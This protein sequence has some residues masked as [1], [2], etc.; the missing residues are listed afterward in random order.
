[1]SKRV[2]ADAEAAPPASAAGGDLAPGAYDDV[3]SELAAWCDKELREAATVH[4]DNIPSLECENSAM[5]SFGDDSFDDFLET[6]GQDQRVTVEE[7]KKGEVAT[8]WRR[9]VADATRAHT[10]ISMCTESAFGNRF[11][12]GLPARNALAAIAAASTDAVDEWYFDLGYELASCILQ[13][14]GKQ[15]NSDDDSDDEP[16]DEEDS[17]EDEEEEESES[18]SGSESD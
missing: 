2:R 13:A 7:H 16:V 17:E 8:A 3:L 11:H 4:I 10:L 18:G 15:A 6:M 9:A 5:D 12:N 14:G 1:M